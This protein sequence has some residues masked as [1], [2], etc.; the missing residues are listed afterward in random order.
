MM[1]NFT[2]VP[3]AFSKKNLSIPRIGNV[4]KVIVLEKAGKMKGD[5]VVEG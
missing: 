5:V 4:G 3:N 1:W 2:R